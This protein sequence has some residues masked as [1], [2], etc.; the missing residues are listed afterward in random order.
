MS[1]AYKIHPFLDDQIEKTSLV[2]LFM[3]SRDF[4]KKK[5]ILNDAYSNVLVE[6]L[7][8]DF[9]GIYQNE[10][11]AMGVLVRARY[12]DQEVIKFIQVNENP[13]IVNLGCGLDTRYHRL[14][15]HN[16]EAF[17]YD[18]D[19]PDVIDLRS[20]LIVPEKNNHY[21]AHSVFELKWMEELQNKHQNSQFLFIA[22]GLF[23]YLDKPQIRNLL[24]DLARH[25]PSGEIHFDIV[26]KWTMRNATGHS[27][28][29]PPFKSGFNRDL[30]MTEWTDK[31][32]YSK[33]KLFTS[34]KEFQEIH[35]IKR[36][37][38]KFPRFKYGCRMLHY[39]FKQN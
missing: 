25:F 17:F 32:V 31:L 22:E 11:T 7:K 15:E 28:I 3:K 1:I 24:I 13:I 33:T 34:E 36:L 29:T 26:N 12:F 4:L 10:D 16:K 37:I 8:H 38:M 2:T 14:K 39:K 20:R 30:E 19:L 35:F 23:M 5:S 6:E 9:S 18:L 21:L 27:N